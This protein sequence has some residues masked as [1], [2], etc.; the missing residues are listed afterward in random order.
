MEKLRSMSLADLKKYFLAE[1][2]NTL[3]ELKLELDDLYYNTEHTGMADERYDLLKDTLIQRDAK[4]VPPVGA[5]IRTDDKDIDLPYFLGSAD[6]ITPEEPDKFRKWNSKNHAS[7]YV[8]SDKL[9]G[10]SCLLFDKDGKRTLCTRGDGYIGKDISYLAP[11]IELPPIQSDIAVRGELIISKSDFQKFSE[12]YENS[13]SMII[14]F[15]RVKT[16]RPGMKKIRFVTYEIMGSILPKISEQFEELGKRQFR[17]VKYQTIPVEKYSIKFLEKFLVNRKEKSHYDIDGIIVQPNL[18]YERCD[19]GL[20][21][22][23]F[24]FKMRFE[25]SVFTTT[26]KEIE[27]NVSRWGQLKPVVLVEPVKT[28]E[29]TI[30]RVTAHHAN[31]V[32]ENKLGPGAIIRVTRSKEVIPYIVSIEKSA[33]EAQLPD[34][35]YEWDKNHVN[36]VLSTKDDSDMCI[37][38]I[39]TFFEKIGAK[40]VA[41]QTI[42]RLYDYGLNT[43]IKILE[44]SPE[45]LRLVDRFQERSA[46][47]IYTSMHS[48]LEKTSLPIMLGASGIFGFGIGRKRLQQLFAD[49]PDLLDTKETDAEILRRILKIDG[50]SDIIAEKILENRNLAILFR[51]KMGEFSKMTDT[52]PQSNVLAGKKFVFSGFRD[53]ELENRITKNGGQS[54]G[55]VS[56]NTSAVIVKQKGAITGKLEKAQELKIPILTRDEFIKMYFEKVS[57]EEDEISKEEDVS[58]KGKT[59]IPGLFYQK[60]ALSEEKQA[61]LL[62]FLNSQPWSSVLKRE[63]QQY[64]YTYNY[65]PAKIEQ[66]QPIP[67]I[68]KRLQ[69]ELG[70]KANQ[71]IVN[72][73]EPGQGITAHTDHEKLFDDV[74][75]TISLEDTWPMI[76]VNKLDGSRLELPLEKGSIAELS[77][78]ARY[79]WTHEIPSKKSYYFDGKV[80]IKSRRTSITFRTVR[81]IKSLV[82]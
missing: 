37:K 69:T 79:K 50:F 60:N 17:V 68:L 36:I 11:F 40:H 15:M 32:L 1:D 18:P 56:K 46:D 9:D 82:K 21:P 57:S 12:N 34:V 78:D 73:Y 6:K 4:Y 29:I 44:A 24:A 62:K 64:G 67:E 33:E 35:E 81:Q 10:V 72:R 16:A 23:M 28:G 61:E 3:H 27:W 7:E 8:I 26:V 20:P 22:Y 71:V 49:F 31:Y 39:A 19:E 52:E 48:S 45:T 54:T 70:I 55:S 25:E 51:N 53:A 41:E 43:L 38:R 58:S 59:P 2:L 30:N 76:F 75:Y 5:K 74:I 65:R 14:S 66:A 77:G 13:R 80:H 42:R 47:R 63:T